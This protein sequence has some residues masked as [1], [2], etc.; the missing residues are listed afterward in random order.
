LLGA[1][2][3]DKITSDRIIEEDYA[4]I[5]NRQLNKKI[6]EIANAVSLKANLPIYILNGNSKTA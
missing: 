2:D 3:Y 4:I 5:Y 1:E 6:Y